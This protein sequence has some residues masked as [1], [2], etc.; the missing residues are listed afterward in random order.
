[1]DYDKEKYKEMVLDAAETVLG[2][3]G[4]DRTIYGGKK[5]TAIRKWLWMEELRREREGDIKME[6]MDKK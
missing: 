1:L 4:F 6:M 3:F 2:Y 5:N